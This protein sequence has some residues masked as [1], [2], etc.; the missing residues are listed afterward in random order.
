MLHS[1]IF[2]TTLLLAGGDSY[3]D[4]PRHPLAPSLPVLTKEENAKLDAVVDKFIQH[5]IGKLPKAQEKQAKDDLYRLGPEA[6]FALVDGFNRAAQLESSCATVTIGKKIEI[7]ISGTNDVDLILFVRENVAAG[8]DDKIKRKLPLVNSIRN[9]QTTCL[10]RKG[11]ILRKGLAV[12]PPPAQPK[13]ISS[14]SMA[15]LEKAAGK[16]RGDTLTKVLTEIEKRES[17]QT[18][19]ILGKIAA[20]ADPEAS[21][22]A[23]TLLFKHAEKQAPTQL[24][25]L[26]K[27]KSTEVRAAA[28]RTIGSKGLRY[29]DELIGLLQDDEPNVQQAARAALTRL[30]DG[31]D[32]GPAPNASF[33][34]RAAAAQKWRTWWQSQQ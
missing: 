26:L 6:I 24:K 5:E 12:A 25:T 22:L 31:M 1:I 17:V 30:S 28:A 16:E 21:K 27:H 18:A 11:E 8:V 14:M 13:A 10:L 19:A 23:K 3:A 2:A 29:G 4:R 15:E 20:G 32:F 33:G 7:I 34:D 9:V